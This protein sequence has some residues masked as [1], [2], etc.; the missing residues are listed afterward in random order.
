MFATNWSVSSA[1]HDRRRRVKTATPSAHRVG[2]TAARRK[3][4]CSAVVHVGDAVL[5]QRVNT[6]MRTASGRCLEE[7][8]SLDM[9]DNQHMKVNLH[10]T[11]H[12]SD[13]TAE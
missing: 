12:D 3:S 6:T 2:K 4:N 13:D 9:N 1:Q 11:H 10:W 8:I 7:C 5:A